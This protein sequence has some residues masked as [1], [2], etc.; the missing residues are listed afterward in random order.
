MAIASDSLGCNGS[1]K[2]TTKLV[3]ATGYGVGD[4]TI[5]DGV[6]VDVPEL[7]GFSNNDNVHA[8]PT[9]ASKITTLIMRRADDDSLFILS[10]RIKPT[11]SRGA[12]ACFFFM[13]FFLFL[14]LIPL[15]PGV[16]DV[17]QTDANKV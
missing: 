9:K 16:G 5:I 12:L 6:C 2:V 3:C 15:S 4:A 8:C 11:A 7:V 13:F 14:G 17:A 10:P 1:G